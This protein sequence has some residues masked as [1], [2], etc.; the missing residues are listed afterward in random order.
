VQLG[1]KCFGNRKQLDLLAPSL[2]K[3]LYQMSLL[4][5][6]CGMAIDGLKKGQVGLDEASRTFV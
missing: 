6:A 1:R 5:R 3:P 4:E 2:L